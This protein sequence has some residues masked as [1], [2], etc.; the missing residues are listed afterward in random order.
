M[1]VA[2]LFKEMRKTV[3]AGGMF[4]KSH[5]TK[6]FEEM[7]DDAFAKQAAASGQLGIAQAM[8]EQYETQNVHREIYE[9]SKT[10]NATTHEPL[11]EPGFIADIK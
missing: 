3:P 8:Q 4:E 1:F 5:A 10:M 6:M 2:T 7:M 11:K 9:Y